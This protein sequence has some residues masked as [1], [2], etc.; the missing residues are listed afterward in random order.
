LKG[1]NIHEENMAVK[2][3]RMKRLFSWLL[4]LLAGHGQKEEIQKTILKI[5]VLSSGIVFLD[6]APIEMADLARA[7]KGARRTNT[8]VWYYRESPAAEPPP[9]AKDVITLITKNR[10]AISFSTKPD[11]S[12]YV[13]AKGV[14]PRVPQNSGKTRFDPRMPDVV[15]VSNIEQIF[16]EARKRAAGED[17]PRALVII[18][19]DRQFVCVQAPEHPKSDANLERIV[20]TAVKRNIAVIGYTGSSQEIFATMGLEDANKAIPFFGLLM[21]FSD[22]GHSVWIFEGHVA[23]IAAG[24]RDADLLLVDSGMAPFLQHGWEDEAA[25][26]MRSPNILMHDRATYQLLIVRKVGENNNHLEFNN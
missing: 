11:F 25:K 8:V 24:C 7:L 5:S 17:W 19:P 13:N 6:G 1:D 21:G 3:M 20:P 10:L 2:L 16:A 26:V 9:Q 12:N 18:R 22:I 14:Y 15:A 23:A 4:A